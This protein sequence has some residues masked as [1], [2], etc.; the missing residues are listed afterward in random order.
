MNF[1]L[2]SSPVLILIYPALTI[3]RLFDIGNLCFDQRHLHIRIVQHLFGLQFDHLLR[4][5]EDLH[6]L[7]LRI[8]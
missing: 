4:L 2:F 3:P 8:N 1:L 5:P 6:N 7:V